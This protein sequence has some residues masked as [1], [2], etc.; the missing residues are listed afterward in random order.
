MPEVYLPRVIDDANQF[1]RWILHT[2]MMAVDNDF[3]EIQIAGHFYP[4]IQLLLGVLPVGESFYLQHKYLRQ[5][6]EKQFSFAFTE[7]CL[8]YYL[9]LHLLQ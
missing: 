6:V 9:L 2:F 3:G 4:I 8:I 7:F 1:I 5:P